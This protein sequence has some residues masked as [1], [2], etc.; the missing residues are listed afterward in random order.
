MRA[1]ASLS[2]VRDPKGCRVPLS[3]TA[4]AGAFVKKDGGLNP[5]AMRMPAQTEVEAVRD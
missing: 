1:T 5:S 3:E 2:G 4:G